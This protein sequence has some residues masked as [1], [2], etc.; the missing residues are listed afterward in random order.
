MYEGRNICNEIIPGNFVVASDIMHKAIGLPVNNV[1]TSFA[2]VYSRS[3]RISEYSMC[4]V[5]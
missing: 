2:E 1:I 5:T 3:H 4:F